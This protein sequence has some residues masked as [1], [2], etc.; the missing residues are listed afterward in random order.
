VC[1]DKHT[2]YYGGRTATDVAFLAG[3]AA[4]DEAGLS[5]PDEVKRQAGSNPP[6]LY[7]CDR[8]V[9]CAR[10]NS[11][12]KNFQLIINKLCLD[13]VSML[14]LLCPLENNQKKSQLRSLTCGKNGLLGVFQ[15]LNCRLSQITAAAYGIFTN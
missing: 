2:A 15:K 4:G 12:S 1:F 11:Y 6:P 10:G 3:K 5:I 7:F 8:L 13:G 14:L 9:T